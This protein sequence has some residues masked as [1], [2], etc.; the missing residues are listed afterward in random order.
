VGST[1]IK[2]K[3]NSTFLKSI[4]KILAE[5]NLTVNNNKSHIL[6]SKVRNSTSSSASNVKVVSE[7]IKILGAPIG[8][9]VYQKALGENEITQLCSG[10]QRL[11]NLY[12]SD[13]F[14]LL[15]FCINSVP[16]YLR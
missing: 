2:S 6:L 4:S 10:I 11:E 16:I 9:I 12:A 8:N 1:S 7:G 15:N 3:L 14:I 5:L 13:A